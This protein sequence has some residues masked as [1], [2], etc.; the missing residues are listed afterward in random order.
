MIMPG[1]CGID[2]PVSVH[3][4]QA[5]RRKPALAVLEGNEMRAEVE[6]IAYQAGLDIIVNAVGNSHGEISG[7]F[8]GDL[9]AAHRTGVEMAKRIY[10]THAPEKIERRR[11]QLLP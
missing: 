3:G 8:V 5:K 1:L 9:V 2:T 10:A 4:E 7:L 11:L 6:A